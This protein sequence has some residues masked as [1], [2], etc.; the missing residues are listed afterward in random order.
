LVRQGSEFNEN[1]FGLTNSLGKTIQRE[2]LPAGREPDTQF[3]FDQLEMPV[4]VAEQH[5]GIGAFS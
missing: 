3:V 2:F 4:M 1:A 5:S